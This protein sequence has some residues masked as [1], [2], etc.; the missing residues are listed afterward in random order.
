MDFLGELLP[1]FHFVG[2]ALALGC[3]TAK[4]VL[5]AKSGTDHTAVSAFLVVSRSLTRLII[6]GMVLVAITGTVWMIDGYPFTTTLIV[7]LVLLGI[8]LVLGPVIDNVIE[9]VFRKSAPV[10]GETA[11]PEFV[12]V[13]KKYIL[14]ETTATGLFYV[15]LVLWMFR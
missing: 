11:S 5:L 10:A 9:P 2:L 14:V 3:G 15:V 12:S 1:V 7:K 6:A 13:R 4:L 8:V